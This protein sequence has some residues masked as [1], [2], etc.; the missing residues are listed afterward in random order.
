[1][2]KGA[3]PWLVVAAALLEDAS[4]WN[5]IHLL[6]IISA[7]W[8]SPPLALQMIKHMADSSRHGDGI[9]PVGHRVHASEATRGSHE[10]SWPRSRAG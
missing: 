10:L 5:S 6:F 4:I 9:R 1:M 3:C 7:K 2:I 8:S